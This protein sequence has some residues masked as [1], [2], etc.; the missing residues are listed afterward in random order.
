MR[1]TSDRCSAIFGADQ[2]VDVYETRFRGHVETQLDVR[3]E[4][5]HAGQPAGGL[6]LKKFLVGIG[7]VIVGDGDRLDRRRQALRAS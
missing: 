1:F 7:N 3:E 5:L 2:Q 4:Q 6:V